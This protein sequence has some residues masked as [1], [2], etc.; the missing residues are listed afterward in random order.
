[1]MVAMGV[2]S[3][4]VGSEVSLLVVKETRMRIKYNKNNNILMKW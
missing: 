1:M 3:G 4:F 2:G